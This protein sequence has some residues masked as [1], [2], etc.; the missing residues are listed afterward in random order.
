[1]PDSIE[2]EL[3]A[4]FRPNVEQMVS[5]C[6]VVMINAPLHPETMNM[7]DDALLANMKRARTSRTPLARRFATGMRLSEVMSRDMRGTCGNL[8]RLRKI[9]RGAT[10]P[11]KA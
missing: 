9:I 5:V 1:L 3:D 6:D 7:F 8:N 10:C 2:K 4:T 11:M